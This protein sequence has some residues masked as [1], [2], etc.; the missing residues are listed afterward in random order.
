MTPDAIRKNITIQQDIV[1]NGLKRKANALIASGYDPVAISQ[2]YGLNLRELGVDAG[3]RRGTVTPA[4]PA[5]PAAF[6]VPPPP[7]GFTIVR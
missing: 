6:G 7:P 5:A 4:A 3:G 1:K 2:A